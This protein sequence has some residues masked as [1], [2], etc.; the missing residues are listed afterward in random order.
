MRAQRGWEERCC[1]RTTTTRG[2]G[3]ARGP[4][5][6]GRASWEPLSVREQ[7]ARRSTRRNPWRG[8][9]RRERDVSTRFRLAGSLLLNYGSLSTLSGFS[10]RFSSIVFSGY[11]YSTRLGTRATTDDVNPSRPRRPPPTQVQDAPRAPPS[12][13]Q[14]ARRISDT[15][16]PLAPDAWQ[17]AASNAQDTFLRPQHPS[18]RSGQVPRNAADEGKSRRKTAQ[19]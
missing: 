2:P 7:V 5:W 3:R 12:S 8:R 17:A 6:G 19:V 10:C 1:Q 18:S 13:N 16:Q 14:A 15:M 9:G 4:S 11:N